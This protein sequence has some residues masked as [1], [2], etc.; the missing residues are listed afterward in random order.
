[1][2]G[3]LLGQAMPTFWLGIMLI[4]VFS[5][6]LGW[7][8]PAG[9]GGVQ[10]LALPAVSL[11]AYS[12]A[13]L[14]RLVRSGMLE[15]L[16]RD[17]VRTARA[18]GLRERRVIAHHALKNALIPTVTLIGLQLGVLFGGAV[19]TE[20][21]FA[22][23]GV[24]RLLTQAIFA[25]DFPLVTA[26]AFVVASVFVVSNLVVDVVYVFLNPRIRYH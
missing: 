17:F 21:I 7:F 11:G 4:L 5:V 22:W 6:E 20:T 24:G 15:V 19:V 25:R 18:K 2:V 9:R 14:A 26:S 1:M 23:P 10:S 12:A 8:P 16:S 13:G 3:A